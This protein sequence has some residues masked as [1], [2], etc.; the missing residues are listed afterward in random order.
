MLTSTTNTAVV[1]A[2]AVAVGMVAMV[3]VVGAKRRRKRPIKL[4]KDNI[5]SFMN[6]IDAVVSDCD[7]VIWSIGK[8]AVPNSREAM[9]C[10]KAAG[11]KVLYATNNSVLGPLEKFR[12][13][14]Y[15]VK[16]N[17]VVHP[18]MAL[19]SYL[20]KINFQKKVFV[21]AVER[22]KDEMRRGGIRVL[23]DTKTGTLV[24][25]TLESILENIDPDPDVGAVVVDLDINLSYTDLNKAANYLLKPDCRLYAGAT[26]TAVTF[27]GG[28]VV[29]GPGPFLQILEDI[30]GKKAEMFGKPGPLM[31]THFLKDEHNLNL[32]RTVFVGDTLVQDMGVANTC[33]MVKLLVLTGMTKLRDLN[34]CP[35]ELI[36]DYIID[37]V[38]DFV[39][40]LKKD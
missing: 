30:T 19:T 35:P 40:L 12:R 25:E 8:T 11:K 7:G 1:A 38:G 34:T 15:D 31:V 22:F 39:E 20:K 10:L 32:H 6:Q 24:E 21:L 14:G 36:P 17:E 29:V 3:G 37:S 4:T 13:F 9:D 2:A 26:D 5:Q 27:D 28:R 23:P 16:P 33:G 18:S